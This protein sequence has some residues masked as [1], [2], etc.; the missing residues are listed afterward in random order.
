MYLVKQMAGL[1]ALPLTIALLL[2]IIAGLCAPLA[3]AVA[4]LGSINPVADALLAP[5]E[6]QRPAPGNAQSAP[7]IRYVVVLGSSYSPGGGLPV[8][9]ALEQDGLVRAVE[10]VRLWRHLEGARLVVSGGAPAGKIASALGYAELARSLGVEDSALIVLDRSLDTADE[11][12][13]VASVVG[14]APFLLVTSAYHMPRAVRLM[15]RA[16]LHPIPAPTGHKVKRHSRFE[17]RDWLPSSSA[18][19]KTERALHEYL[20]LAALASGVD[21]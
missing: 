20:G 8:T 6:R 17:L 3:A 1:L 10:G 13:A 14:T 12:R 4:Y 9:A 15:E 19:N 11:A 7:S 18:L 21:E 2:V 5:L 16:G